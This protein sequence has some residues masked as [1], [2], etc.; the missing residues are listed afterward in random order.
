MRVPPDVPNRS[1]G[2]RQLVQLT[3]TDTTR[4][5]LQPRLLLADDVSPDARL[6]AR[7]AVRRL[8]CRRQATPVIGAGAADCDCF[9]ALTLAA[10]I[11][12]VRAQMWA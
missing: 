2:S 9:P 10:R 5:F 4:L 1:Y 3:R 12:A 11:G 8:Y 6:P 7:S